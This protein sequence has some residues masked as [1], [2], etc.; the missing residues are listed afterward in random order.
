[1]SKNI[2]INYK[3]DV[4]YEVLYPSTMLNSVLDWQENLYSKDEIL[5]SATKALYGLGEDSVP[6]DV[7][8]MLYNAGD[9]YRYQRIGT[10]TNILSLMGMKFPMLYLIG[11]YP[12]NDNWYWAALYIP[13]ISKSAMNFLTGAEISVKNWKT[14]DIYCNTNNQL[15]VGTSYL[16]AFNQL[17]VT[18]YIL[19]LH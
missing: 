9:S 8:G 7:L 11:H 19:E 1:M 4:G 10:G 3:S 2:E 13:A 14:N 18:Y 6:K 16:F 17:K 5:D 12:D 15:I